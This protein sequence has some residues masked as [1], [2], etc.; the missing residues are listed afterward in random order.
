MGAFLGAAVP[1]AILAIY[2]T[3]SQP[4]EWS[5]WSN[6]HVFINFFLIGGYFGIG[7]GYVTMSLA[8]VINLSF[9]RKSDSK[10]K[11][12][13][14]H[15]V[16]T[17]II[18]RGETT[19]RFRHVKRVWVHIASIVAVV[20]LECTIY[21]VPWVG[22]MII[23]AD[24]KALPI[25]AFISIFP[26]LGY[27]IIKPRMLCAFLGSAIP[28]GLIALY[29]TTTYLEIWSKWSNLEFT[30]FV[31]FV[32]VGGYFGIGTGILTLNLARALKMPFSR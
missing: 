7:A 25:L 32:I 3:T 1:L 22:L 31:V 15:D 18:S 12:N 8:Q 2:F 5:R 11:Q 6:L 23:F 30:I 4:E 26:S 14:L 17:K 27:L 29:A 10:D 16:S 28:F 9:L 19:Q 24:F 13:L 20:A 21:V